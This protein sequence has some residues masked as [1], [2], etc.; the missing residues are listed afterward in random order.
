M[1]RIVAVLAVALALPIAA[2]Q[3]DATLQRKRAAIA[4]LL[5]VIDIKGI[6]AEALSAPQKD[7]KERE[8]RKR[9]AASLDTNRLIELYTPQLEEMFTEPEVRQLVAF[10]QTAAGGKS[11][12]LFKT[13]YSPHFTESLLNGQQ[14]RTIAEQIEHETD[15][16]AMITMRRMRA[17]AAALEAYATD[18]NEYPRGDFAAMRPLIEPAYI[19]RV[20]TA[21]GWGNEFFYVTDGARY[22][23][24]SA[25]SDGR[26]QWDTR[27]LSPDGGMAVEQTESAEFDIVLE[28]GNF[29]RAPRRA[30]EQQEY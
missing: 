3:D 24:A 4:E 11:L 15:D 21:D 23:F 25:G 18:Y 20:P 19:K 29:V 22:R 30:I 16:P 9:L 14:A 12:Q 26:F 10:F 5:N 28:D 1:K 6:A 17:V 8:I 13:M 27:S 2:Q 7:E